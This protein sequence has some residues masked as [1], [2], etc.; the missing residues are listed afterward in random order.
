MSKPGM[1]VGAILSADEKTVRLLGYGV[2]VGDEVPPTSV[3]EFL[4]R[5]GMTNPKIALDNGDT[6]W[7]CKCWW[8]SEEEVREMIGGREIADVR[9]SEEGA[10][11]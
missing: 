1:R 6:V 11:Q 8:A 10:A 7:G 9:I 5:F 3:D 4:S 2:Y